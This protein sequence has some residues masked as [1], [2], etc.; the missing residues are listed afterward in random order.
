MMWL[1]GTSVQQ[2]STE[3]AKIM[4]MKERMD[5]LLQ[6]VP[7]EQR[8]GLLK[9]LFEAETLEERT[10]IAKRHIGDQQIEGAPAWLDDAYDLSDEELDQVAGGAPWDNDIDEYGCS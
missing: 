4:D 3:G 1:H 8:K 7:E 10:A 5:A 6:S 2:D 9:E